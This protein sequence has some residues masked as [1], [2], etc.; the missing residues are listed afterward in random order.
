MAQLIYANTKQADLF[1]LVKGQIPDAFFYLK[2]ANKEYIFLDHREINVFKEH[3]HSNIEAVLLNPLMEKAQKMKDDVSLNYKLAYYLLDKYNLLNEEIEVPDYFPLGMADF[4][5]LKSVKLTVKNPLLPQRQFKASKEA[6]KIKD[7]LKKVY[8]AYQY[9]EEVLKSSFI[10]GDQIIYKDQVLTSE[11]LKLE[12]E[13]I[14]LQNGMYN[15]EGIIVASGSQTA[16]P[17][18]MGSGPIKANSPLICDIFPQSKETGYFADITRTYVKGRPSGE[19]IKMYQAVKKA[20]QAAIDFI[21][22]GVIGKEV[23]DLVKEIFVNE[24]Y[25]VDGDQGFI[26][27]TGHGLGLEVHEGPYLNDYYDKPL[28]VCNVVTVEPGLYYQAQGGVRIEDVVIITETGCQN[29][30]NYPKEFIEIR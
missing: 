5:R 10:K 3:N 24:G 25:D 9:L 13:K 7:S 1:Y 19:F 12:I 8:P 22:P 20:Q 21:K 18:H 29:L 4:L 26:H 6:E 15:S 30:T 28:A 17:H 11:F 14:L 2:T 23:N 27:G 16:I